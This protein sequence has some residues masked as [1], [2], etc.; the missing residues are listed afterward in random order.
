M[1]ELFVNYIIGMCQ[2]RKD[3]LLRAI[4]TNWK[5]FIEEGFTPQ[6]AIKAAVVY[7]KYQIIRKEWE[8]QVEQ[9]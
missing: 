7:G 4:L 9:V 8:N 3:P 2:K 5:E 6:E 1:R